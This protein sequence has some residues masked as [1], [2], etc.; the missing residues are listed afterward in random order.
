MKIT[1]KT[2]KSHY[3]DRY[4]ISDD[5]LMVI[6]GA[7][8]LIKSNNFNEACWMVNYIKKNINK[9]KGKVLDRLYQISKDA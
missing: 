2:R 6:D 9:Y 3:E 4:I 1:S 5:F 7:T 8:P